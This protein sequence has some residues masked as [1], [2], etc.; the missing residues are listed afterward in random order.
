[1]HARSSFRKNVRASFI[2]KPNKA[3]VASMAWRDEPATERRSEPAARRPVTALRPRHGAWMGVGGRATSDAVTVS[4]F[5]S[6][7]VFAW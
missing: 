5:M 4:V 7:G 3:H 2:A 1:M 6:I